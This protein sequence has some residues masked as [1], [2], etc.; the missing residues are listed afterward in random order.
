MQNGVSVTLCAGFSSSSAFG[1][2]VPMKNWPPSIEAI[3]GGHDGLATA[4]DSLVLAL[5]VA[6]VAA[7][8]P[9]SFGLSPPRV[10][11][12]T[13]PPPTAS[14]STAAIAMIGALLFVG[15]AA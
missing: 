9:S 2:S 3:A 5:G 1:S 10:A 13:P 12:N 4:A 14:P 7:V 8:L 6:D 15:W 11:K